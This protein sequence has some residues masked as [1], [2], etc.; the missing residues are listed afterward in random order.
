MLGGA[1]LCYEGTEKVYEIF[2]PGHAHSHEAQL[3]TV[4]LTSHTLEDEKI[5]SAIKTD[6]ILSAEIMAITLAAISD[7]SLWT[8]AIVLGLVGLGIT[9]AVYGV[10]A[11]IVKADDAGVALANR[12]QR[13]VIGILT[14]AVGRAIVSG[15]PTLLTLLSAVGTAA[16]IWVG[17]GI[18]VHGL[19]SY[20]LPSLG[21][22]IHA[23]GEFAANLLPPLAGAAEWI[24]MAAGSGIVGLLIGAILIPV[25]G[26]ALAPA[27]K[28]LKSVMPLH[29]KGT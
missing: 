23:T 8:Q 2:V 21:R 18:I 28:L 9:F 24:A 19:E 13:S 6:F 26:F 17:G 3:G 14:R 20:G 11:L 7:A 25:V 27:W 22:A 5:A 12:Q 29:R 15:M 16:M 1:Y 10:V 4:A